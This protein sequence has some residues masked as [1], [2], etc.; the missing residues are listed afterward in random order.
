MFSFAKSFGL[1]STKKSIVNN[2]T[3]SM[4]SIPSFICGWNVLKINFFCSSERSI[5][6]TKGFKKVHSSL[7]FSFFIYSL[8]V[9][10]NLFISKKEGA[11][12]NLF[13]SNIFINSS[14]ENISFSFP[15][16]QPSNARK[17]NIAS[18]RYPLSL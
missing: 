12:D 3:N 1:S 14:L 2:L 7:S 8:L 4:I 6:L 11:F 5:S 16:D 17:L 13:S 15:V 9:Q 18:G 10:S